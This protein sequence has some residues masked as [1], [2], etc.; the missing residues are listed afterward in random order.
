MRWRDLGFLL[1]F[2]LALLPA[3]AVAWIAAGGPSYLGTWLPL[4]VIFGLL[5]IIDYL[6]GIDT[7]NRDARDAGLERTLVIATTP[8]GEK[9]R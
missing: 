9:V 7:G 3:G 2:G 6:C 1:P 4:L 5:P 8:R